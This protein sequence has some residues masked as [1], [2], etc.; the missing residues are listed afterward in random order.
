MLLHLRQLLT[1]QELAQARDVLAQAPP[2]DGR[3]TA[4]VQSAHAKNNE[5]LPQ[6]CDETCRLLFDLDAHLMQLRSAHGE[7][8][9]AVI[10][11][12]GTYHNLLRMWAEA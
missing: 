5:Q 8:D 10:G 6:A 2:G 11:L 12:T 9:A 3:V 1:P 4:G 7:A